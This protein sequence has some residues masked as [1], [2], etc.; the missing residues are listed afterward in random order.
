MALTTEKIALLAPMHRARVATA[1]RQK[2]G[3]LRRERSAYLKSGMRGSGQRS[4]FRSGL[5]RSCGGEFADSCVL[6]AHS[7]RSASSGST[8]VARRAGIQQAAVAT[9][10]R[11]AEMPA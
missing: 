8:F 4:A 6:N 1:T 7:E 11:R 10:A 9:R 5:H 2:P 3:V